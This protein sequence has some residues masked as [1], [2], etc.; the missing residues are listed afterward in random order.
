MSLLKPYPEF[1]EFGS[2]RDAFVVFQQEFDK[3]SDYNITVILVEQC[4][5]T[6]LGRA[7]VPTQVWKK[8]IDIGVKS[9]WLEVVETDKK[10]T[11][12]R[13]TEKGREF[14]LKGLNG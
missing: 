10:E 4:Y 6:D 12:I 9:K 1:P 3:V 13:I 8:N 5:I 2:G 7:V 11:T 14:Y